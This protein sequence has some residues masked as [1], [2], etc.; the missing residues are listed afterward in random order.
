MMQ[1][2][3]F[4]GTEADFFLKAVMQAASESITTK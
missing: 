4:A 2:N 3:L 1:H